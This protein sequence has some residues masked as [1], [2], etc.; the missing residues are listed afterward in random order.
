MFIHIIT[1]MVSISF[2]WPIM[3]EVLFKEY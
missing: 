3:D 2:N 1:V